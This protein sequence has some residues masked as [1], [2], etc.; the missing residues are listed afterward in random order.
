[1]R[2]R[3]ARP[4]KPEPPELDW[5]D[6]VRP[7]RAPKSEPKCDGE[8][9]AGE[10]PEPNLGSAP[11]LGTSAPRDGDCRGSGGGPSTR[12][13]SGPSTRRGSLGTSSAPGRVLVLG[14]SGDPVDETRSIGPGI[15]E[16]GT[17]ARPVSAEER[18]AGSPAS[19]DGMF[20]LSKWRRASRVPGEATRPVTGET[21]SEGSRSPTEGMPEFISRL[22]FS[23]RKRGETPPDSVSP[24][25]L[26]ILGCS[27]PTPSRSSLPSRG[28]SVPFQ[29]STSSSRSRV[30]M[31][32]VAML[33]YRD[34]L[35]LRR[36]V[37]GSMSRGVLASMSASKSRGCSVRPPRGV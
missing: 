32:R 15:L 35:G 17:E 30:K 28:P 24:R 14:E 18:N 22:R 21:A 6:P 34:V 33:G 29:L 23:M 19:G 8:D 12:R 3:S 1:M 16:P 11:N 7:M 26:P 36:G 10:G 20:E 9:A 5:L 27:R 2:P 4:G 31:S 25:R 37:A 13:G